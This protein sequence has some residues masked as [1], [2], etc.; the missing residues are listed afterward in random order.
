M[1]T[2][3]PTLTLVQL[4]RTLSDPRVVNRCD[5]ELSDVLVIALCCLLCGG[6]TCNDMEEFGHAK[7]AW[8]KTFLSL[9][10]SIV[11]PM[12]SPATAAPAAPAAKPFHNTPTSAGE[13]A[14]APT[15][16]ADAAPHTV[17]VT[18]F[19]VRR[20]LGGSQSRS[21]LSRWVRSTANTR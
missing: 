8:F 12:R 1:R 18:T 2:T 5:H 15:I 19:R 20:T 10:R 21:S 6:E 14:N 9:R 7:E 4:F 11:C 16:A 13:S 17:P 3:P